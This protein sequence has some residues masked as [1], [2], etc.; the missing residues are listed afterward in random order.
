MNQL[1]KLLGITTV[2]VN[3]AKAQLV[4]RFVKDL[5][6]IIALAIA[7]G[8]MAGA[9]LIGLFYIAYQGLTYYGLEPLAAQVILA[10]LSALTVIACLRMTSSRLRSLRTIP[11]QIIHGE[12]PLYSRLNSL[13]DSFLEGFLASPPR[14]STK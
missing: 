13:V 8:F 5:S 7:T 3:I 14:D 1:S 4:Q 9:L 6:N 2:G 12:F 10:F 11:G